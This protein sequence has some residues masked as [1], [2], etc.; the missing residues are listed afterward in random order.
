MLSVVPFIHRD[1]ELYCSSQ[2]ACGYFLKNYSPDRELYLLTSKDFARG[3]R[4]YTDMKVA[5]FAPRAK[6]FFSPHPIPFLDTDEKI[7]DFLRQHSMVYCFLKKSSLEYLKR[8]LNKDFEYRVLNLI[9]NQYLV[10]IQQN[11]HSQNN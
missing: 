6:N 7:L 3:A 5:V 2:Y 4:Y 1:I 11:K 9:G 10:K 8:T